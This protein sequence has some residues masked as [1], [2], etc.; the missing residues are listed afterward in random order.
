MS[1]GEREPCSAQGQGPV[2]VKHG[3]A[4]EVLSHG[5][6]C[7]HAALVGWVKNLLVRYPGSGYQQL[8]VKTDVWIEWA[9][10]Q[11]LSWGQMHS[12]FSLTVE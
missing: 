8:P 4:K 7:P 9:S 3:H 10:R 5:D 6:F 11:G 12:I 1:F 2:C